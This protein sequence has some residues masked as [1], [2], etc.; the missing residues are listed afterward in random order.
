M[1]RQVSTGEVTQLGD[2]RLYTSFA[3][4]PDARFL[5]VAW[6]ERPFSY[7]VPCGRFPKRVQLWDRYC[8]LLL[9][10]LFLPFPLYSPFFPQ[11]TCLERYLPPLH[12]KFLMCHIWILTWH[13]LFE[14][15]PLYLL[16]DE[17]QVLQ[18]K[19]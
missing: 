6:L 18:M 8:T 14:S 19:R 13:C 17:I 16:L 15:L 9:L 12:A 3:P 4:S 2:T 11:F 10:S 5:L 7:N 1:W